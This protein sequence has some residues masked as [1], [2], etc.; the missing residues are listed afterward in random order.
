MFNKRHITENFDITDLE[1]VGA[2]AVEG[3]Y[4]YDSVKVLSESQAQIGL[5]HFR[6]CLIIFISIPY[7][8]RYKIRLK[9]RSN[10]F[11]LLV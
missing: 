7:Q 4:T 11:D 2:T 3:D 10:H 8:M 1:L 5:Y 9:I 6:F